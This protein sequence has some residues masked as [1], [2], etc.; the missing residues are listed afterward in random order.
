MSA[1]QKYKVVLS[2]QVGE[3]FD[4]EHALSAFA[5]LFKVSAE[6]AQVFFQG[7]P[8]V[9]RKDLEE[10]QARKY[11]AALK[12]IGLEPKLMR[13]AEPA[14]TPLELAAG[15]GEA[16]AGPLTMTCPKCET[17]QAEAEECAH[18]GIIIAKFLQAQEAAAKAQ[19]PAAPAAS[20]DNPSPMSEFMHADDEPDSANLVAL[21]A[22]AVAALVGALVWMLIAVGFGYELGIVAWGIGGAVGLAAAVLGGRG[23][24]SGAVCGALALA[25]I[26]GGKV[27]AV[28]SIQS[29]IAEVMAEEEMWN[30]ETEAY[31]EELRADART[32][33]SLGSD[34]AALRQF[35]VDEGYTMAE[36]A[37]AVSAE[38]LE[39]FYEY[40]Q[41]TLAWV[42]TNDPSYEEWQAY[43]MQ[44]IT[45]M[46]TL[47][48]MTADLGILDGIF[49]LL[50][51]GTAFRLGSGSAG[52]EEAEELPE[53]ETAEA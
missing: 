17:E 2:G 34:E 52:E 32:Y 21:G 35:M 37:A 43:T 10:N 18:C 39:F 1:A 4:Q 24:V 15:G 13:Q 41:P 12:K 49:L 46:S 36:S 8:R 31:F 25:A 53:E 9:L 3:G 42:A 16:S 40:E 5:E 11:L 23:Q 33:S 30:A 38:D 6:Q 27:L 51:I 7:K 26:L 22:A 45:D 50:G 28:G 48:L 44:S 47:D 20:A 19:A 29:S 14:E